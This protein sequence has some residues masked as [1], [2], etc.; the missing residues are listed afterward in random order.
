MKSILLFISILV[1]NIMVGQNE[2]NAASKR[3]VLTN[4][5]NEL[6]KSYVFPDQAEII[7]EKV[8]LNFVNGNYDS[9]VSNN[10]FARQISSDMRSMINDNH[11]RVI[12][13]PELEKDILMFL[14]SKQNAKKISAQ[15]IREDELK[16]FHFAKVEILPANIGYIQLNG[17]A[18]PSKS[19]SITIQAAM[20]FVSHSDAV[21][22]D[23]RNNFGGN[24][25]V[26]KEILSYFF[27][28]KVYAGKSYN[29]INDKWTKQYVGSNKVDAK[30]LVLKMPVY[31]L[32]SER[33]FSA[34]EGFAYTLQQ[35]SKATIVGDTTRGGAHLTRSFSLGEGYV[36]FIPYSRSENRITNT[37]WEGS[38]VIPTV[39]TNESFALVEAQLH[40][41][42]KQLDLQT[43]EEDKR[44]IN[45]VIN[46][47]RSNTNQ[48]L[49]D[50]T[51]I[52][53][54][55]G[56][57]EYFNVHFENNQLYFMDTKNFDT[58]ELMVPINDTIFQIGFD[59]QIEFKM[60]EL[61]QCYA[62]QMYWDDGWT[63]LVIK[64]K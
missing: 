21:I 42:Y 47:L 26:A 3:I 58:P 14:S 5:F 12:Y 33:T 59:Y 55:V 16:N 24:A 57:Y 27:D 51:T 38:G 9:I 28:A 2:L 25:D 32:V 15:D 54:L 44:K 48:A 7:K 19:T 61:G 6:E 4:L 45:Y 60:N 39:A 63:E 31:V 37:D 30:K 49:P 40:F 43:T 22:L 29:R 41:L 64:N 35:L 23:L 10:D 36:A 18:V 13:D 62:F 46:Y 52:E 50:K 11:L 1:A 34:A 53:M 56:A 17:F 20:Q 8:E